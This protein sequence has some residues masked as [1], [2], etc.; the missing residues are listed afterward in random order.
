MRDQ[1]IHRYRVSE[2][3]FYEAYQLDSREHIIRIKE[4]GTSEPGINLRALVTGQGPS[5]LFIHGAPG[6]G[7]MWAPLVSCLPEYQCII[8]DRPGCGLSDRS[9]ERRVGKECVSTC[10]SRWSPNN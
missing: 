8:L 6:A 4:P 1:P 2:N 5:L 10:R 7:A 9:E 3:A